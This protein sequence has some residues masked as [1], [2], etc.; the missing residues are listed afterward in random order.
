MAAGTFQAL[1]QQTTSR[2]LEDS[3]AQPHLAVALL[4]AQ[5]ASQQHAR[6]LTAAGRPS[7]CTG[8]QYHSG[9]LPC[10]YLPA[11]C[12]AHGYSTAAAVMTLDTQMAVA[13]AKLRVVHCRIDTTEAVPPSHKSTSSCASLHAVHST[14]TEHGLL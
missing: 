5:A 6:H 11:V 7:T 9:D 13:A 10:H 1:H 12:A 8:T 3:P 2:C 4:I 14:L